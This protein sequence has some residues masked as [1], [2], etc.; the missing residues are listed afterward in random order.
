MRSLH[1]AWTCLVVCVGCGSAGGPG[2]AGAAGV[3]GAG[4]V[5]GGSL[6]LDCAQ[7][8]PLNCPETPPSSIYAE[9]VAAVAVPSDYT[10]SK[11]YPL[12]VVLHGRESFA[13]ADATY[14]GATHRVD[15]RQFIL[16]TPDGTEDNE[17]RL[18]WNAGAS[19]SEF[20][21]ATP[22]DIGYVH[23]LIE[24]ALNTFTVDA[25]RIYLL[26]SS[27]GGHLALDII[28]TDPTN[29]AAVLSQAGALPATESCATAAVSLL[30]VHG[31]T[32]AVI[33]FGGGLGDSGITILSA[34]DL[35]AG[36]AARGGCGPFQMPPNL[37]LVPTLPGAET[38]VRSYSEC[39]G[40]TE[41]ALWIVQQAPHTPDFSDDA[42]D[43]WF[44]WIF[45][46]SK[47]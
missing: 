14:L 42:R 2:G 15:E 3:G 43:L 38:R 46:K 10:T 31:T 30:S 17:G 5:G 45:A 37:D 35:V 34:V 41:S 47:Q 32:D 29:I 12:V 44:D 23:G 33:P 19:D 6:P 21:P 26:G 1:L 18:A 8:V 27:N 4:G 11:R 7:P 13:T 28:C 25:D 40:Q 16:V 24:E 9:R 39:D 20:E 36:V 22:D